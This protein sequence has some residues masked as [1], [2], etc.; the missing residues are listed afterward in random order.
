VPASS[1]PAPD[2]PAFTPKESTFLAGALAHL[3][4]LCALVL[5]TPASYAR[6][7]D[8]A[9][10]GGTYVSYGAANKEAP[11][12]VCGPP[13]TRRA[14]GTRHFELKTLDATANPYLALAGVLGVG[15]K[16]VAE[17]MKLE[18]AQCGKTSAAELGEKARKEKG[19][20]ERLPQSIDEARKRF[21]EDEVL[22]SILG[23]VGE[24]WM[25]ISV[26]S[27]LPKLP[28]AL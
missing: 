21:Q 10:A 4:G 11:L 28:S 19:V 18:M 7:A 26:V 15:V 14:A 6:V 5:P 22:K 8:G 12:R 27:G 25:E 3:P 2:K 16:A 20:T 17:G 13:S 24:K 1:E 9:H 23:E